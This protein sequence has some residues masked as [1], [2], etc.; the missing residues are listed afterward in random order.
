MYFKK[1]ADNDL[2][3]SCVGFGGWGIGGETP[4][5][6]SYGKTNE[7]ESCSAIENALLRGVNFFDTSPAYGNG[8]SEVLLG[9]VLKGSRKNIYLATKV[10]YNSWDEKS[11]YSANKIKQSLEKSLLRLSTDYVDVLW[12]HS[13]PLEVI[14]YNQ[15]VFDELD[16]LIK[17]GYIS[18]WGISAKNPEDALEAIKIR[19]VKILQVNFNM[20]DIRAKEIGLFDLASKLNVSIV[21]RT[22]LCFGFLTG[23]ILKSTIFNKGDH[24]NNWSKAQ[25]DLWIDGTNRIMGS[26]SLNPGD[27]MCKIAL[28]FCFSFKPVLLALPGA[29][30]KSETNIHADAGDEGVLDYELIENIF[31]I[32]KNFSFFVK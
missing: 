24:R 10:G 26:L 17:N 7:I 16:D 32:H 1:F 11:D 31:N 29:L 13:P 5:N 4:G 23:N 14:K 8:V 20:M 6:S 19:N 12:L 3:V 2:E 9:K 28:R 21:A 30:Y 18:N 25:K 15:D 22:P 27:E